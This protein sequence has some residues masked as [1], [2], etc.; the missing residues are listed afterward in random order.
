MKRAI[1]RGPLGLDMPACA[2]SRTLD[3]GSS[4]SRRPSP[5]TL[6]E[7]TVS[8][9]IAPGRSVSSGALVISSKPVAIIVP[10]DEFGGCT[11]APRKESADSSSMLLAMLRVK[12]TMIVD[13]QVG[14]QLAEHHPQRAGALGD[15]RLDELFLAQGQHLA[16]ERPRHVGDVDDADDQ[17]RDPDRAAGDR[18]RPDLQPA[19]RQ[20]GPERDR[21][22]A[23]PGRPR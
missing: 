21:R 10:Q 2:S 23:A 18:D 14:Q 19:D 3:F 13:Q 16:A 15:G 9:I 22:A 11:P 20:R 6:S 8:R 4:A 1:S 7:S 5:K 12:K 17:D